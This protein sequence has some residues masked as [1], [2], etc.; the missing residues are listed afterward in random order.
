MHDRGGFLAGD[1]STARRTLAAGLLLA[2][3]PLGQFFGAPVLGALSDRHRR[4]PVL[5]TSL[6]V[7]AL[8]YLGIA[9]AIADRSLALLGLAGLIAGLAESNIAIA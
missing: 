6:A 7:S 5:L 3:Y 2:A 1:A 8:C 4:K 9:L